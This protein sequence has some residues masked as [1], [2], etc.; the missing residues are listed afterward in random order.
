MHPA[1]DGRFR[2]LTLAEFV[3]RL[4]SSDPVPGGGSASATAA[5]LAAALVAMVA[6]LSEGRPLFADHAALLAVAVHQGRELAERFLELAE[7]DAAAY[8]TYAAALKLP[9]AS[10]A[11]RAGRTRAI[12]AAARR[13]AEV[14]LECVEACL[15]IVTTAEAL[16]GRSNANASSDLN[17]AALLAEAAARGAAANVLVNLPAVHDRE[18]AAAT[19]TRVDELL[20]EISRLAETT[21]TAVLAGE[22][23]EPLELAASAKA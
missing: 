12:R 23:R 17:V 3:D 13:A 7:R 14:P 4:A 5:S 15:L 16:A 8:A 22:L 19:T 6:A 10:L 2:D 11:E 21:G 20:H 18:F 9:R 1:P